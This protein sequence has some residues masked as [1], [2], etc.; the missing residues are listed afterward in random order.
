MSRGGCK[1]RKLE[2]QLAMRINCQNKF[3]RMELS[4]SK[5]AINISEW[6]SGLPIEKDTTRRQEPSQEA[7]GFEHSSTIWRTCQGLEEI[8]A[9]NCPTCNDDEGFN[10][11]TRKKGDRK[12]SMVTIIHK[13]CQ[14]R[15]STWKLLSRTK[16]GSYIS[17]IEDGRC[18]QKHGKS[19]FG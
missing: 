13:K 12:V 14:N 19:L 18:W 5:L 17:N 11:E 6:C 1:E 7:T 3:S 9:C 2:C 8:G 15:T 16:N 4:G 10:S